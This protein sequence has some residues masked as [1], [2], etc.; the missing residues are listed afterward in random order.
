MPRRMGHQFGTQ[1]LN[2]LHDGIGIR[3]HRQLLIGISRSL[4]ADLHLLVG[5]KQI[6]SAA[7][8]YPG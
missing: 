3:Q 5:R 8:L 1:L 7:G 4:L 2:V 6:E